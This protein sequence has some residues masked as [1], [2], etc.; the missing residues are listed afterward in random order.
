ME[1]DQTCG[2]RAVGTSFPTFMD[3]RANA[4]LH[5]TRRIRR[6]TVQR[7][8]TETAERIGGALVSAET[9]ICSACSQGSAAD[10]APRMIRGRDAGRAAERRPVDASLWHDRRLI[11]NDSNQWQCARDRCA[12]TVQVSGIAELWSHSR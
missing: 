9:F 6:A 11:D 8:R 5:G 10:F 3:W 12:A 7:L 2:G 4:L 1:R